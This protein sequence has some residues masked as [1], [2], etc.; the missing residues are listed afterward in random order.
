MNMLDLALYLISDE[1]VALRSHEEIVEAFIEGEAKI[2]Q[3]RDKHRKDRNL[4]RIVKRLV[5]VCHANGVKLI[6]NDRVDVALLGGADGVHVG[7]DDLPVEEVRKLAPEDFIIGVTVHSV[8]EAVR[9]AQK[10]ATY[11]GAGSVYPTTT[12]DNIVL[13]G[14]DGLAD[15]V[16]AVDIP[17]VAI[18]GITLENMDNVIHAGA[19]GVAV[20]SAIL[21]QENIA[22]TVRMFR[23]KLFGLIR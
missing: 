11:L 22:A 7:Q 6:V 16:S 18:G 20:V 3:I 21:S 10:G 12:K 17:V 2:V 19:S 13:I 15:I 1:E 8:E 5:K 23:E 9:A 14:I 4:L